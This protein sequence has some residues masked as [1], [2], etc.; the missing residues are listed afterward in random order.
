[1]NR[2]QK[3]IATVSLPVTLSLAGCGEPVAENN[4]VYLLIDTSGTYT[5][6]LNKA[7][8]IINYLLANLDSG[9]SMAVARIDSGSFSEKD[10]I[11]KTTFDM[12]PSAANDQKRRFKQA[13]DQFAAGLSHGSANTDISGGVLQATQYLNE[14][15][16]GNKY[17]F[18][19]SD[20]EEDL[21]DD[22]IRDFPISLDN[23]HVV[24]LNVTKLR[25]DNIDP[26]DYLSRLA[27]WQN[28]VVD[29][30]GD[31]RVLND[32]E[33]MEKLLALQ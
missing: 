24:A 19:F 9:D 26:R 32:L 12:R 20:L 7:Q 17:V 13:I 1:M 5:A 22:H 33:R 27:N 30:G 25:S 10:I 14:T 29:G 28:R 31:W 15:G 18:I 4:A 11:A 16:A 6:E 21:P 23:I 3:F 2:L 8:A